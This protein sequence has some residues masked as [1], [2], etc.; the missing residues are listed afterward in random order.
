MIITFSMNFGDIFKILHAVPILKLSTSILILTFKTTSEVNDLF[1][2]YLA[3]D[4]VIKACSIH[5][6]HICNR[7]HTVSILNFDLTFDLNLTSKLTSEVIIFLPK[8]CP[9]ESR[10]YVKKISFL[11]LKLAEL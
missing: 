1:V 11:S 6:G 5:F 10:V 8:S 9:C 2:K 3:I 7:L 4:D